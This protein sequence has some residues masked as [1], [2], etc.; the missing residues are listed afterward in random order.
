MW[1][2][3]SA[4]SCQP[5]WL[6]ISSTSMI[7]LEYNEEDDDPYGNLM[8]MNMKRTMMNILG[9][10]QCR[11][12][13]HITDWWPHLAW[14]TGTRHFIIFCK[15][16]LDDYDYYVRL[17]DPHG[18]KKCHHTSFH[19]KM[20]HM[21][22]YWLVDE[23]S[24]FWNGKC[25]FCCWHFFGRGQQKGNVNPISFW[26]CPIKCPI[27]FWL[28]SAELCPSGA[29]L[30]NFLSIST[31]GWFYIARWGWQRDIVGLTLFFCFPPFCW[32]TMLYTGGE[33]LI[34]LLVFLSFF[35]WRG[36]VKKITL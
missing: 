4:P 17:L 9:C 3:I 27:A 6:H 12:L 15:D 29:N 18:Q 25:K 7:S 5:S 36:A 21:I 30:G 16:D 34:G 14:D 32:T 35:Y 19:D 31:D 13:R 33:P 20:V 11:P 1:C 22:K 10:S 28:N 8:T 24:L 23:H 26:I 2:P